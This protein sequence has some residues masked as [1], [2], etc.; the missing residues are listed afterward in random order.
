MAATLVVQPLDLIKNRMQLSGKLVDS[1]STAC[2]I[3]WPL[4]CTNPAVKSRCTRSSAFSLIFYQTRWRWTS[5]SDKVDSF[6]NTRRCEAGGCRRHVYWVSSCFV[7]FSLYC[8][9]SFIYLTSALNCL[10]CQNLLPAFT[11]LIWLCK[12]VLFVALTF[13]VE[14][15]FLVWSLSAGLFRQAT[16]TTT[17]MGVYTTIM[18]KY[19]V[20]VSSAA[21]QLNGFV[22]LDNDIDVRF[23]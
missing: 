19:T 23:A 17:R 6:N 16:Y 20:W 5:E 14:S 15:F 18:E 9:T 1:F 8:K 13:A 10:H 2:I 22:K 4:F 12:I 21:L 3:V 11:I 7:D